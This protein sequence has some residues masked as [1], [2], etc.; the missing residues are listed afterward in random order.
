MK[1]AKYLLLLVLLP[2]VQLRAEPPR[3]AL[4]LYDRALYDRART[5]FDKSDDPLSG[6]YSVL[7]AIRGRMNAYE[8]LISEYEHSNPRSVL[9]D[10]IHY[11][12]ALDL[13]ARGNYKAASDQFSLVK[14]SALSPSEIATFRFDKAWCAYD[15]GRYA[16][17]AKLFENVRKL[18]KGRYFAPSSYYLGVMAYDSKDFKGAKDFF[19]ASVKD[20]RLKQLSQF[21]ILECRFMLKDYAY[22]ISNA[23][24]LMEGTV[25]ERKARISR[26]LSEAYLIKGEKAMARKYYEQ[27]NI[28][29]NTPKTRSDYFHAGS[30]LFNTAEYEAAIK[31]FN[32]MKDR[33][34]SIGQI[35]SYQLGYCYVRTGNKVA[36]LDAFNE[37][38]KY[39]YNLDIKEDA[40]FNYAKLAFDLNHDDSGFKAYVSTFST[41]KKGEQIYDYMALA[42]LV[43]KDYRGA[44]ENYDKIDELTPAQKANF[45]K[46]NY[47]RGKQL[48]DAQSWS[49]ATPYLHASLFYFPKQ[50]RFN[51]LARYTLAEA[52]YHQEKYVQAQVI[53]TELFNASALYGTVYGGL[54]PYNVA[55]CY[56]G[57]ENYQQSARWL[58]RYLASGK[59]LFEYDA[60][61][62]RADCDFYSADYKNAAQRYADLRKTDKLLPSLYPLYREGQCYGFLQD[63]NAKI[64]VLSRVDSF[65]CRTP[66]YPETLYELGRTYL[67]ASDYRNADNAFGRLR[68]A[69]EDRDFIAKAL[70]G[71]GMARRNAKR[72]DE[73]LASYKEIVSL[74]PGSEYSKDALSAIE[75]IYIAK[76]QPQEYLAWLER[77]KPEF[78]DMTPE[79]K[80]SLTFV[81]AERLYLSGNCQEAS[82][83]LVKFI[84]DFPSSVRLPMAWFYLADSYKAAGEKEKAVEAFEKAIELLPQESSFSESAVMGCAGI[85]YSLE[86]FVKACEYYTKALQICRI[87]SNRQ[88]AR[89]GRMRSAYKAGDY[90]TAVAAASELEGNEADFIKAKSLLATSRRE[91]AFSIFRKLSSTPS[92]PEGAESEFLLIQDCLD[93]A[94]YEGLEKRVFAFAS[95]CGS[96]S[97]F[98]AKAYILL[99]DSFLQRGNVAQA[100]ATYESIRDGYTGNDD[101]GENVQ[102]RLQR[103]EASSN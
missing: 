101:I 45:V 41:L 4:D 77:E 3:E 35:A 58:D 70:V 62:R 9:Y 89:E 8:N 80:D 82:A 33:T 7:C 93:R 86:R 55:Y 52:L 102:M 32:S 46:A 34:D 69:V 6:A 94:D 78:T 71:Q 42:C 53:F 103:M 17:A 10:E 81:T 36:A 37:A 18:G 67:D 68:S 75:A 65:N 50:D 100:K 1:S 47:L 48:M 27:E 22:V 72:Y 24:K 90:E 54:L 21:Y 95:S 56:Y 44:I 79:K 2:V 85:N 61:E 40:A 29:S 11:R 31:A 84:S 60:M 57:T 38:A 26:M 15:G 99:G 25:P 97:Y 88:L 96:Q 98:L 16:E 73:A 43:N 64:S 83:L 20:K 14:E 59:K 23:E 76:K 49:D 30:V 39:N 5:I 74:M 87:E 28:A 92:T 63:L 91:E 13:F 19:E 66:Y 12:Y 51:Q